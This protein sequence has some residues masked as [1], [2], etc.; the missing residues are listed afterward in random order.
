MTGR[1][2]PLHGDLHEDVNALLPWYVTG[3]LDA[4][5]CVRVEAHISGCAQCQADLAAERR[6]QAVVA[7]TPEPLGDVEAAWR[8]FELLPSEPG[9][10]RTVMQQWR[11]SPNW[12]RWAVAAQLVLLVL[13]G[14]AW[15]LR[16]APAAA[17]AYHTLSAAP[18]PAAANLVVVFRPDTPE[19]DL[20]RVLRDN[21][22]RLVGGPTAADAYLLHVTPADRPAALTRLRGNHAVVLAEPVDGGMS[23]DGQ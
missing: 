15:V 16:P 2:I 12:M 19:S 9:T 4:D 18:E 5:D 8:R 14:G 17:P 23:G 7:E 10:K 21:H 1:I 13:G 20:R 11:Q 22:A 3:R 6:L